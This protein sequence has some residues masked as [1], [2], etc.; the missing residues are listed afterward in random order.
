MFTLTDHMSE[1]WVGYIE[2]NL[3]EI[4]ILTV[5][6]IEKKVHFSFNT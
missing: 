1:G 6:L 2:Y 3:H 5:Q 4:S